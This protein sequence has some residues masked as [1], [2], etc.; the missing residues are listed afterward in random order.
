[1]AARASCSTGMETNAFNSPLAPS[2]TIFTKRTWPKALNAY[3]KTSSL[4][5]R[6]R[7]VTQIFISISFSKAW[8]GRTPWREQTAHPRCPAGRTASASK[9][10]YRLTPIP[11][12]STAYYTIVSRR[13]KTLVFRSAGDFFSGPVDPSGAP[14]AGLERESTPFPCGERENGGRAA[15]WG[16]KEK[17]EPKLTRSLEVRC[18]SGQG[19]CRPGGRRGHKKYVS[20]LVSGGSMIP[21]PSS[22]HQRPPR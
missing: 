11:K 12:T 10:R 5:S 17:G 13:H 19:V 18:R 16:A 4:V 3:R 20:P 6:D 7:F 9:R 14:R 8:H 21:S 15:H 1:M 2:P 22:T